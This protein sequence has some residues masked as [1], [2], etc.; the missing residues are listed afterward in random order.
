LPDPGAGVLVQHRQQGAGLRARGFRPAPQRG[1]AGDLPR[2]QDVEERLHRRQADAQC[3]AQ[4][5]HFRLLVP[6]EHDRF[7]ESGFQFGDA[8]PG[9]TQLLLQLGDLL[10]PAAAFQGSQSPGRLAVDRLAADALLP[11]VAADLAMT[12]ENND[13]GTGNSLL[14]SYHAHG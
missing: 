14:G 11:G 13:E 4:T 6:V 9:L 12:T 3:L 2:P 5:G 7:R 8:L 10:S 1:H